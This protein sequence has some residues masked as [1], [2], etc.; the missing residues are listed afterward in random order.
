MKVTACINC[1]L[2]CEVEDTQRPDPYT[3]CGL[4]GPLSQLPAFNPYQEVH[5]DCPFRNHDFN[6]T[7]E[8]V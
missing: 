1:P 6:F 4:V 3:R 5:R 7:I 8:V 2:L